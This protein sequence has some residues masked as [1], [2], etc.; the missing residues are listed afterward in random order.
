M[1]SRARACAAVRSSGLPLLALMRPFRVPL[2]TSASLALET[3]LS[4]RAIPATAVST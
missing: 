3:L 1:L 2:P 4:G